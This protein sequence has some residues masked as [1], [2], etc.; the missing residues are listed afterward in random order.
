MSQP[1]GCRAGIQVVTPALETNPPGMTSLNY[2]VGT[3][4]TFFESM[5][6]RLSTLSVEIPSPDGLSDSQLTY[7]LRQLTTREQSDP[8]IALLD[9]WAVVADVLTFYQERI[10]NEGYLATATERQSLLQLSR[11]VNYTPR[12]GASAST[13]LAFTVQKG[14]SGIIPAGTRA[15]SL[16]GSG[17]MPQ[18]YETSTDLDVSSDWNNLQPRL[19]TPQTIA[20]GDLSTLPSLHLQGVSSNVKPGDGIILV[21]G[22]KQML[23]VIES[24]T[25]QASEQ[26]TLTKFRQAPVSQP[27]KTPESIQ[28]LDTKAL[29]RLDS[30]LGQLTLAPSAQPADSIRLPRKVTQLFGSEADTAPRLL[31]AFHPAAATTLYSALDGMM[32][33]PN[34]AGV[35]AA[36]VKAGIFANNFPGTIS[37]IQVPPTPSL[38]SETQ[39]TGNITTTN[40]TPPILREALDGLITGG[41]KPALTGLPLDAVYD[42]ITVGSWVAIDRPGIPSVDSGAPKITYHQVLSVQTVSR[43]TTTG[44]FTAKVTQLSLEPQWLSDLSAA[45]PSAESSGNTN[46]FL[47]AMESTPLLRGT[48]IYTQ[49]EELATADKP[50]ESFVKGNSIELDGVYQGLESGRWA[51]VSGHRTD[52]SGVRG[53]SGSELVMIAGVFQNDPQTPQDTVHTSL[54]LANSL[55]YTYDRS[56][57]TICGNVAQVTNGQTTG[58]VL[59]NGDASAAFQ[60]FTLSQ[61]PV[62]YITAATNTGVSSTLSV[63]VNEVAWQQTDDLSSLGPH[64]RAY[65]VNTD[66]SGQTTVTFGNGENGARLPSGTANVKAVYR[67]GMGSTG[68]VAAGQIS[69]LAT[70]P[71]G[72]QSVINPLPAT[73]GADPDTAAQLRANTSIALQALDRLVSVQDYADFSRSYAGV[74]KAAAVKLSNGRRQVVHV[75]IAGSEDIPIALSSGLYLNLVQSLQQFGDPRQPLLVGVRKLKLLVISAGM[76]VLP[77]FRFESVEPSVQ[78][79]L[80]DT[81]SFDRRSL[82]QTAFLSEAI[83]AMQG[84]P[85]VAFVNVT[86]FDSVSED[87]SAAALA[88]LSTTLIRR[89][90]VGANAARVDTSMVPP[91]NPTTQDL[92]QIRPAEIVYLTPDIADTLVLTQITAAQPGPPPSMRKP[93]A[94]SRLIRRGGKR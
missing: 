18:F 4:A 45:T 35:Y 85:G 5:L 57:V 74:G 46:P 40:V 8:S 63:T 16:P 27:A 61:K 3:Y 59:G 73:G 9:A 92:F 70:R 26:R 54:L 88:S 6:A 22:T 82:G 50:I 43:Q 87:V 41:D 77:G 15:Q 33:A 10:A 49:A 11:L 68:N 48:V 25:P 72:A 44:G 38:T 75:T 1:C 71:L 28:P 17:E 84:V 66:D 36:R 91:E 83:G 81:F 20:A 55:A 30:V 13:S 42:Q 23:R 80:L 67:Y 7:P 56:T 51:I 65:L 94:K 64:D 89:G 86:V 2:R 32:P 29:E 37:V 14:F 90:H 62:T 53:V 58:Q 69:Q 52:I 47:Q 60:T 39:T 19:T 78:A 93:G 24:V 12:P 79:A 21:V 34:P 31:A 76:E